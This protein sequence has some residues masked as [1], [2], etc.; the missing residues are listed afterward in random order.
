M[1]LVPLHKKLD[2]RHAPAV[3]FLLII[4]NIFV[5]ILFQL[6]DDKEYAEAYA[7]YQESGLAKLE[8]QPALKYAEKTENFKLAQ[9][10]RDA[11]ANEDPYWVFSLQVNAKFMRALHDGEV[12]T[13]KDPNFDEWL[14]KRQEFDKRYDTITPIRYGL[15]TAAPT[16][17]TFF[18]HMF[19]HADVWHLLGNM[20]ILL[21]VG[22]LVEETMDSLSYVIGYLLAGL[23]SGAFYVLIQSEQL[24]PGIGASG[25][26]A[27]LMGAYSVL[28][29]MKKIRFFYFIGVYFNY[30][31]LPAIVLLPLWI[32]N[33]LVSM[34]L[35][36]DSGINFLAHLGGLLSGAVIAFVIKR[37]VSSFNIASIEQVEKQDEFA[38]DLQRARDLINEFKP[39]QALTILRR[40]HREYPDNREILTSYYKCSRLE[41]G[42]DEYHGLAHAILSLRDSDPA[43]DRLV[44]HTFNEYLKLARPATRMNAELACRLAN[45]FVRQKAIAEAERLMNIILTKKL[46]CVESGRLVQNFFTL[47][48]EN[49]RG[50]DIPKYREILTGA[51]PA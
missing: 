6:D 9:V 32:T 16:L 22:M 15:K 1:M 51:V 8:F 2:W 37:S 39:E 17:T 18:S 13:W 4:A 42:S 27:G 14:S 26:I 40:L 25:A 36:S 28:Y 45:R 49:G 35:D 43:T 29:G 11:E 30:I 19:L 50:R 23:G 48:E 46:A 5:F 10:L 47:L 44:H 7:Y 12:I 24:I 20:L 3:T 41:P 34:V 33:E 31:T 38:I 21:A